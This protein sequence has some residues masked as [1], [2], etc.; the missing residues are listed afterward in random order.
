MSN[1]KV[2]S[3]FESSLEK[4]RIEKL[5]RAL[6]SRD[7]GRVPKDTRRP[8]QNIQDSS[9]VDSSRDWGERP[10]FNMAWEKK[11]EENTKKR[12]YFFDNFFGISIVFFAISLAAAVFI[13]F[14]GLN[15]ISSNNVD[16]KITGPSSI[17]SGEELDAEL[18]IL[19]SNRTDL[20]NVVLYIDYPE[21]TRAVGSTTISH[22]KIEL[23]NIS[24]G[25]SA[26]YSLRAFFF[27]ETGAVRT[28][29]MRLEYI[30]K[31]SDATFSKNK[32]YDISIGSSP[33]ILKVDYPKEVNSGQQLSIALDLTSN[34]SAL[35]PHALVKIE[36]PYGFTY[37]DASS[38]PIKPGL[39]DIGDL[40]NGDK[41]TLTIRG[42]LVGQNLEERT[43]KISVG[44][45]SDDPKKDFDTELSSYD[46]TIA[47][48][49]SFFGLTVTSEGKSTLI[50]NIGDYSSVDISWMNTLAD[51]IV[52]AEIAAVISGNVVNR[53]AVTAGT[54]GFYR[55]LDNT[56]L[57][58]K[59][60]NSQL[61]EL[62]PGDNGK[63]SFSVTPISDPN[64]IRFLRNPHIDIAV[65]MKGDRLSSNSES[66]NSTANLTI[67]Y[68]S[69]LSLTTK[70]NK[71]L[72]GFSNSQ[73]PIPP[74][75]D[76]ETTYIVTWTLTN[77]TNDLTG[78]VV[79]G[80]LPREVRWIGEP[81]PGTE[82]IT[83]NPDTKQIT[84]NVGSI[85][86]GTG[87]AYSPKQVSFRVGVT[88]SLTSVGSPLLITSGANA[89]AMDTY[90]STTLYSA[91]EAVGTR[92]SDSTFKSGDDIVTQ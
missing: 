2:P 13:F 4:S 71:N 24:S 39:W 46:A 16:I 25:K 88:P 44:T 53:S 82:R 10:N 3:D 52:N 32:N 92:Y 73:G 78:G 17:S 41:K 85:P 30:V 50:S 23:G 34:S 84:W 80:T 68:K 9:T 14:G 58:D 11:I 15:M 49:K 43:F 47:L 22:D 27:G 38:K 86:A 5:K 26:N 77:T 90:A 62:S 21:G 40:K 20:Q 79:T 87:F 6:Y 45:K 74:R 63:V 54:N 89:S 70:S 76:K 51:K 28:V 36:F 33:L 66:I 12:N 31:G 61:Q 81:Q 48:R 83:Y 56:V 65:T 1:E 75:A 60:S 55:S 7:E 72:A 64:Q 59:N 57:W 42:T 67:K 69:N 91:G 18:S 37:S 29:K 8:V 19:N 35:V